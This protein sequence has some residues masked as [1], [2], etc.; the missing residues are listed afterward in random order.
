MSE[1]TKL[2]GKKIKTIRKSRNLLQSEL[3]EKI[4][5]ETK[6]V[7]R[8][9]T[10]FS[11]PSLKTLEKIALALDVDINCLLDFSLEFDVDITRKKLCEKINLYNNQ[12]LKLLLFAVNMIDTM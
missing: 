5:V 12:K 9:E 1:L 2:L 10:G 3:A 8:L 6:Y 11:S 7:S 4:G